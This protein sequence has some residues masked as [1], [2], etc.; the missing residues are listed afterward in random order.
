MG[1]R[2][3]MDGLRTFHCRANVTKA[4]GRGASRL[5]RSGRLQVRHRAMPAGCGPS[6]PAPR[7]R[8]PTCPTPAR[9]QR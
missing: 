8:R 9:G 1:H 7:V 5:V 4:A 2:K 6:G 3:V